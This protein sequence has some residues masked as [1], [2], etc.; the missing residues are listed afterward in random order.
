MLGLESLEEAVVV[1]ARGVDVPELVGH[2]R[3]RLR[4]SVGLLRH[5][6]RLL[7]QLV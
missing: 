5:V 6:E 7:H 3:S 1:G 2:G 4:R